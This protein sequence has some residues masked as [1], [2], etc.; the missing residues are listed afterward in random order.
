MEPDI[1]S[2]LGLFRQRWWLDAVAGEGGWQEAI[3]EDGGHTVGVLRYAVTRRLG[4]TLITMPPL[5]QTLGPWLAP[6][7]G[8]STQALAREKDIIGRLLDQ[9]PAHAYFAQNLGPESTNWLPWHWRGYS[10]STRCTYVLD[11]SVGADALWDGFLPKVRSDVRKAAARFGLEVRDDLGLDAFLAVQRL[12]FQRQGLKV[13]VS[14]ALV[15]RLDAA[16]AARD[17]RRI[18]FAV[19]AEGRVHAAAYL[20]WD[21]ARAYYLMGGGDPELRN[22]GATSLVLWEAI[23]FAAGRVPVFD[24]EGSMMEPVER[25]V[26]GFGAVQVPYHRVWRVPGRAVALA[27]AARDAAR[28]LSPRGSR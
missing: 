21:D 19:D 15:Q 12:T 10:Q 14:D 1:E 6:L 9:L 23:R 28:A 25:F 7:A 11:T 20:V 4:Q 24:F 8:K 3:A 18:F 26:R 5:T 27:M 16:C 13:P 17:R 2:R 22:S